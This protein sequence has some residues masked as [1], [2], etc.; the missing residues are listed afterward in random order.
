MRRPR[1]E[2]PARYSFSQFAYNIKE[3]ERFKSGLNWSF[4]CTQCKNE[5]QTLASSGFFKRT[6][7]VFLSAQSL[8]QAKLELF[9]FF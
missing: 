9:N 3:G 7:N 8:L 1:S 4:C 6:S 2:A 5:Q